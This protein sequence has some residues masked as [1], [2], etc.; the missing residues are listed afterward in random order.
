MWALQVLGC[1][2]TCETADAFPGS[3][4]LCSCVHDCIAEQVKD[5]LQV[6]TGC[7]SDEPGPSNRMHRSQCHSV[8]PIQTVNCGAC[9]FKRAALTIVMHHVRRSE[10]LLEAIMVCMLCCACARASGALHWP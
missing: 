4:V 9:A 6:V 5:G 7:N 2:E 1:W 3:I 8:A 10:R